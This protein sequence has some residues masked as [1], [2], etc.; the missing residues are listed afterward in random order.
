MKTSSSPLF[1]PLTFSAASATALRTMLSWHLDYLKE[2]PNIEL[3][4]FAYTLQHRRS[5]LPYR[6]TIAAEN[7][8]TAIQSLQNIID[9]PPNSKEDAGLGTRFSTHRGKCSTGRLLAASCL[10]QSLRRRCKRPSGRL[11]WY[12]SV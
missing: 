11:H 4:N 5:T 7:F 6:K 8:Q 3:A 12:R 9:P 10:G 2:N 1:T